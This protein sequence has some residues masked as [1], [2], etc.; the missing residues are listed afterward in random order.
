MSFG[1]LKMILAALQCNLSSVS[2]SKSKCQEMLNVETQ[3]EL[4][5]AIL[6]EV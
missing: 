4:V 5:S 2:K 6:D 1:R 3:K